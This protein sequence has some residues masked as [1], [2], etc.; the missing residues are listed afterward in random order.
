[1]IYKSIEL[2]CSETELDKFVSELSSN[3]SVHKFEER[4]A[5]HLIDNPFDGQKDARYY[6]LDVD[7]RTFVQPYLPFVQGY[8]KITTENVIK[9]IELHKA[10][11]IDDLIFTQFAKKPEDHIFKLEQKNLNTMSAL[12]GVYEEML[13]LKKELSQLSTKE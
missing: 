9:S 3:Y 12:A 7:N 13:A 6:I 8:Q 2:T 5:G 1:M 10:A 11:I 4:Y